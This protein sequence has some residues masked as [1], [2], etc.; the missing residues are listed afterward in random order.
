MRASAISRDVLLNTISR[1]RTSTASGSFRDCMH[2]GPASVWS[3]ADGA[4]L[5]GNVPRS[6]FNCGTLTASHTSNRHDVELATLR[7]VRGDSIEGLGK[8][9]PT[10]RARS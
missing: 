10:H 2:I 7:E 1:G 8:V 6:G 3:V 5:R 4:S 9:R